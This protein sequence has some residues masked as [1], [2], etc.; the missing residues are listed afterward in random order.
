MFRYLATIQG[1][2]K[3]LYT[4]RDIKMKDSYVAN[5]VHDVLKFLVGPAK[6]GHIYIYTNY[7]CLENGAFLVI[8]TFC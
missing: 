8:N 2:R 3:L 7:T 4:G 6:T 1:R 5:Y